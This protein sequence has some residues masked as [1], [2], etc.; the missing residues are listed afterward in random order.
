MNDVERDKTVLVNLMRKK[1]DNPGTLPA[2]AAKLREHAD[3]L[4]AAIKGFFATPQTVTVQRFVGT[5]ARARKVWEEFMGE[6][7]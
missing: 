4:D 7:I 3:L 6:T 5:W 1:A 2:R